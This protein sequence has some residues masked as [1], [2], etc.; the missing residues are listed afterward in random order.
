M[1]VGLWAS[2]VALGRTCKVSGEFLSR[3]S[4][5]PDNFNSF[6]VI[7]LFYCS[8]CSKMVGYGGIWWDI[9]GYSRIWK[10]MEGYAWICWDMLGYVRDLLGYVGI[11]WDMLGYVGYAG[12]RK[13]MV[14]HAGTRWDILGYVSI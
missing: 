10:D 7:C 9:I 3:F 11:C 8:Q 13:D 4:A 2:W 12:K 6:T 1:F 14:G 5:F